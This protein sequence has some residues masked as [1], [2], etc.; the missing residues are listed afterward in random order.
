MTWQLQEE[1][2]EKARLMQE[3]NS[4]QLKNAQL[5][6]D[7]T[8]DIL[9]IKSKETQL[10]RAHSDI[11]SAR[12]QISQ[13]EIESERSRGRPL[14]VN[15]AGQRPSVYQRMNSPKSPIKSQLPTMEASPR[16]F[17]NSPQFSS[18]I[19]TN[20]NLS[21]TYIGL[22]D[23]AMGGNEDMDIDMESPVKFNR[24]MSLQEPRNNH[25]GAN[26]YN[27][28]R[29]SY[30]AGLSD[31]PSSGIPAYSSRRAIEESSGTNIAHSNTSLNDTRGSNWKRAAEVTVQLKARIEAM[32]ARQ[33]QIRTTQPE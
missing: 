22:Q 5:V 10:I 23:T 9:A 2:T 32:K 8:R 14:S 18:N 27:M 29:N 31:P 6:E 25:P 15:T 12:L 24:P 33:S 3:I 1:T 13:L 20:T 21:A 17:Q 19:P 7:H 16:R 30:H 28:V 4:L 26:R 11:E